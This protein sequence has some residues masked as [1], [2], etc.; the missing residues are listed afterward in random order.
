MAVDIKS[1]PSWVRGLK[2]FLA[3]WLNP[4]AGS[5]PSWVRGLKCIHRPDI[6]EK[7]RIVPF[8]GTGIKITL[9]A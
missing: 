5:Y 7:E 4:L 1:Y 2:S 8:M 6:P 3:G 9:Q